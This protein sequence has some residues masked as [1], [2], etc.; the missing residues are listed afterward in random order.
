LSVIGGELVHRRLDVDRPG[1]VARALLVCNG[2]IMVGM[3][4][5]ALAP[6]F[7]LAAA[8]YWAATVARRVRRPLYDAWLNRGLDP[9]VRA[10]VLSMGGQAD[11][12]GQVAGG[13]VLGL[14]ANVWSIRAA[15]AIAGCILWPAFW[16]YNHALRRDAGRSASK[17]QGS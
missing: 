5:F 16:L 3:V 15:I 17:S 14:A 10:T 8:A 13:P 4:S 1:A 11:A 2:V 6:V 12:L 9:G 7:G